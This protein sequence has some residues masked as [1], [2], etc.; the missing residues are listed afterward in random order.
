[1]SANTISIY[2]TLNSLELHHFPY[3]RHKLLVKLFFLLCRQRLCFLLYILLVGYEV[4]PKTRRIWLRTKFMSGEQSKKFWL[5]A[6]LWAQ[7]TQS[8]DCWHNSAFQCKIVFPSPLFHSVV[9]SL[10][11]Y[12]TTHLHQ[13]IIKCNK[14]VFQLNQVCPSHPYY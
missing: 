4:Q 2:Y 5:C 1:M 10:A 6:K 9:F 13:S 8:I 3:N 7:T 11:I 14:T 12:A